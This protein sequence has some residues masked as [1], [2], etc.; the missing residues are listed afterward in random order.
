MSLV[1][2]F[3]AKTRP[4]QAVGET[5]LRMRQGGSLVWVAEDAS[6][7]LVGYLWGRLETPS[8]G[9]L[10]Q[11]Y[12]PVADVTD[13]LV[14]QAMRDADR[15]GVEKVRTIALREG[16]PQMMKKWG[17]VVVGVLMERRG[18]VRE[19]HN[20]PTLP[21]GADEPFGDAV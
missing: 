11:I 19:M 13:A 18:S 6:G 9:F 8:E 4:G 7:K 17:F 12:A 3:H 1:E 20:I 2:R 10:S 14:S 16:W 21:D 5:L 15:W